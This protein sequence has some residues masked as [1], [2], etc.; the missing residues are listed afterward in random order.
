M[1]NTV[2]RTIPIDIK[3]L[4]D[5]TLKIGNKSHTLQASVDIFNFT[6]FLNKDWGQR[7][8]VSSNVTPLTT[9][10]GGP[11]PVFSFNNSVLEFDGNGNVIDTDIVQLDDSGIQSSRWQMQFGVRY[12]F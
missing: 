2:I 9:V 8:F 11:D 6:N 1:S 10:S 3:V 7:K 5:F 12:I 4:Q